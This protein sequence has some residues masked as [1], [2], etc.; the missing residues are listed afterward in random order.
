[1]NTPFPRAPI[2]ARW[3]LAVCLAAASTALLAA[4]PDR[5]IKFIVPFPPGGA[6]DVIARVVAQELSGPLGQQVIVENRAGATGN[7]GADAVA[8]A[9]PDGYTFL[10][11]ALTSHSINVTLQAGK[12]PYDLEK[13]FTAVSIAGVV[14]LVFVVNPTVP[15][16]NLK[17]LIALAKAKPGYLTYASSGPGGPQHLAGELFKREAGVDM[18]HV[19]YKGSGPAMTDL[20]GGQVLVMV[21][22]APAA[23]P[24]IKSNKL[25]A[26]A[27]ASPQR[28]PGLE[29]VPTASEAG[30]PGFQVSS[31]FGLMAPA[32]TPKAI[33]TKMN[34][35]MVRVLALPAVKEKLLQQ[36]VVAMPMS[37]EQSA[38]RIHDEIAMWAK[39]IKE[40]NVKAD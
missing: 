15:A 18:L 21:E 23:M 30:L 25:R 20:I 32:G 36:G 4:W 9:A 24:F 12:L 11:G 10:L 39:V 19:P 40:A 3:L 28:I 6:T 37:P 22:T 38:K 16:N 34:A 8:K 5:P 29:E 14:P 2:R 1:M 17:E 31:M 26:L 35:E 7:I 13:D 33:I 27:A